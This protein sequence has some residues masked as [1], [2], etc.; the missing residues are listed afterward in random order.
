MKPNEIIWQ[1]EIPGDIYK[2]RIKKLD[3]SLIIQYRDE[4]EICTDQRK[5]IQFNWYPLE[6]DNSCREKVLTA[7][8][9]YSHK[10]ATITHA[11]QQLLN[12]ISKIG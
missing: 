4:T 7:A 8:L 1:G 6:N 3:D 10:C 2:Y 9:L 5:I 12:T 11:A